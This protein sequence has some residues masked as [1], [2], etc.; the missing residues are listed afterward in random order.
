MPRN[1]RYGDFTSGNFKTPHK[2]TVN[3]DLNI[4]SFL[5]T[6]VHEFAHLHTF[7]QYKNA[8]KP[9]GKEW[10]AEFKR[11]MDP[12]IERGV[13]PEDVARALQAYMKDPA[14]SSC[15]DVQLMKV[16]RNYDKVKVLF[17]EEL[18]E[19]ARFQ[20]GERVFVKGPKK[21]TRF[22]CKELSSGHTYLIGE[23]AEIVQL[24]S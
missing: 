2:I 10:K 1:S 14:A 13:F 4:F 11:L 21:R 22:V 24:P 5:I 15:S 12:F 3:G 23:M 9:H 20:F 18:S 8:V 19:G 16:L 7:E 17:L 6:T